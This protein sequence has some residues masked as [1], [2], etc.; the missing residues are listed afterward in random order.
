MD[1]FAQVLFEYY[2][3]RRVR[4][5]EN[6]RAQQSLRAKWAVRIK[7]LNER[8]IELLSTSQVKSPKNFSEILASF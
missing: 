2:F 7:R 8:M 1:L 5:Q 4:G 6:E 3:P